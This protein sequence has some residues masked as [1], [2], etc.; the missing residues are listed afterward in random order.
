VKKVIENESIKRAGDADSD[1]SSSEEHRSTK[2]I[3]T[4]MNE[5][6]SKV[7]DKVVEQST[8]KPGE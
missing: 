4:R 1:S 7:T 2:K 3:V 8:K 6:P 5:P